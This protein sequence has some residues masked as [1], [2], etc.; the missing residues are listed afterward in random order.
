ML[1]T[2]RLEEKLSESSKTL[3][4]R[5]TLLEE[6]SAKCETLEKAHNQ[7]KE[8]YNT[9]KALVEKSGNADA[10]KLTE[11]VDRLSKDRSLMEA[12]INIF[13]EEI[14]LRDKDIKCFI[15]DRKNMLSDI[16]IFEETV[17]RLKKEASKCSTKKKS[18]RENEEYSDIG[19]AGD[20]DVSDYVS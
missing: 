4:D 6:V 20:A 19:S 10:K 11:M 16:K 7:L 15:E 3:K 14:A 1:M 12:D 17:K 18:I 2:S 5:E 13:K 9:V 8:D